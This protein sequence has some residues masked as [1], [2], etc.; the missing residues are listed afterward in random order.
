MGLCLSCESD[1][2]HSHYNGHHRRHHGH[3]GGHYGKYHAKYYTDSCRYDYNDTYRYNYAPT[4]QGEPLPTY[5]QK[6]GTVVQQS[7]YTTHSADVEPIESNK[8]EVPAN[9]YTYNEYDKYRYVLL[10]PN[11]NSNPPPYNPAIYS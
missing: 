4:Y 11:T 8:T 2:H 5:D 7:P 10:N 1:R 6:T 3:H 9:N